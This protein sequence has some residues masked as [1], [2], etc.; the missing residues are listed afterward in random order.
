MPESVTDRCTKSHEYIFLLAKS[1]RYYYDGKAIEEEA[2]P[3]SASRYAYAFT[4]TPDGAIVCPGDKDGQRYRPEG[5]REYDGTRNK[6]SVWTV[7]T[8]P[9]KARTSPPSRLR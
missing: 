5:M 8:Q 1:E 2:K 4:G 9:F 6:R 7:T 3:E